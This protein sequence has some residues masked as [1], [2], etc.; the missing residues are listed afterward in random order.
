[1]SR[2]E[3]LRRRA[4]REK[5]IA[6]GTVAL[7]SGGLGRY[8][9][10]H[11]CFTALELPPGTHREWFNGTVSIHASRNLIADQ[12][13][14]DWLLMIDDDQVYLPD[15]AM[16]LLAH[17]ADDR[18]DIVVPLIVQRYSPHGAVIRRHD[19][20]TDTYK[21]ITLTTERGLLEVDAAGTGVMLVRRRVFD[22][23]PWPP[24]GLSVL[25]GLGEDIYFCREATKAGCRVWCD[26][27]TRVGHITPAAVWP[28]WKNGRWMVMWTA[29]GLGSV[30][31]SVDIVRKGHD[32]AAGIERSD[33]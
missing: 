4:E 29:L 16:R 15:M 22:R 20:A 11:Q 24:F 9:V 7:L 13:R 27:E 33:E 17:L 30:A 1:M 31:E 19:A 18:I 23:V 3:R 28:S 10:A 5:A 8:T 2:A 14:G 12:F 25:I 21:Q 6:P 32:L 26:L